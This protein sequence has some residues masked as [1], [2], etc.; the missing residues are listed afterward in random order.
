MDSTTELDT[1]E[2]GRTEADAIAEIATRQADPL[3]TLT[4]GSEGRPDIVLVATRDGNLVTEHQPHPTYTRTVR[5]ATVAALTTYCAPFRTASLDADA[6]PDWLRST[7]WANG[8]DKTVTVILDDH[9]T[10]RPGW[11][12]HRAVLKLDYS[13]P[14]KAWH[15]IHS[16]QQV[17]Q[18]EMADFLEEHA[19]EV[20]DPHGA[21]LLELARTFTA[22]VSGQFARSRNALNGTTQLTWVEEVDGRGGKASDLTVPNEITIT[23]PLLH[24]Q[25]PRPITCRFSYRVR[26]GQLTLGLKILRL[27]ELVAEEVTAAARTASD[28]LDL[29]V[30]EGIAP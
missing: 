25:Q 3:H 4:L 30:I 13:D 26:S 19:H 29:E 12:D 23:V 22:T 7:L 8:D 15:T 21:D 1:I 6:D 17:P 14:F 24:G 20:T 16:K 10:A 11:G 28:G 2:P 27:Q 5:V 18:D 9:N